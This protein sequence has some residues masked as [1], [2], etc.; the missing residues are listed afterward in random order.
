MNI[1]LISLHWLPNFYTVNIRIL[2]V[3]VVVVVVYAVLK[4][5]HTVWT[6]PT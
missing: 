6:S 5:P 3:F 4:R 2:I 1:S